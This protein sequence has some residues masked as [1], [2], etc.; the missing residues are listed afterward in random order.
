VSYKKRVWLLILLLAAICG[1][2]VWGISYFRRRSLDNVPAWLTRIPTKDAVL[3][4]VDLSALRQN[5]VLR[6]ISS[7]GEVEPEYQAFVNK[8]SFDYTQD[9]DAV[10]AS[11]SP[12]GKYFLVR[13]RFD[14]NRLEEYATSQGGRCLYTFC[15]LNGSKPDRKISYF[16]LQRTLMGLAVSQRSDAAQDLQQNDATQTFHPPAKPLWISLPGAMLKGAQ[17]LP[18]G[19]RMFASI[20]ENTEQVL[21]TLGPRNADF[22]AGLEVQCR[23]ARDAALLAGQ[24]TQATTTVRQM[25][26]RE[27]QTPNPR[28]LSGVLTSG[29]FRSTGTKVLGSWP[30][31]REFFDSLTGAGSH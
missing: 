29:E 26:A 28:D 11:F 20:L 4:Y 2:S 3:V 18:E 25:I 6:L 30:I 9:L 21:L 19:T 31:H 1:G 23:S 12:S 16:P 5:G 7:A 15:S 27:Q 24:L 10:L 17:P 13:G 22:E 14:W 8:T